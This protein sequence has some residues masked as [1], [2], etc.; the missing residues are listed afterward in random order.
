MRLDGTEEEKEK[1][2]KMFKYLSAF[3]DTFSRPV[4]RI[5]FLGLFDTVNS[6][7]RF[8]NA[9]MQR[10]KFPYTAKSSAI[11]IRHAV[12]IDER[13]AKFRQDLIGH[14][15][16]HDK[17]VTRGRPL[18]NAM[19]DVAGHLHVPQKQPQIVQPHDDSVPVNQRYR[20]K[21]RAHRGR[22]LMG[23]QRDA[24][25]APSISVISEAPETEGTEGHSLRTASSNPSL[26]PVRRHTGDLEEDEDDADEAIPQDLEEIWFP[27]CHAV[28]SAH[29]SLIS[30]HR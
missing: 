28:R 20:R 24:S 22:S 4:R 2:R 6:V 21:S 23:R 3:R 1:K 14:G 26:R 27:G 29:C 19:A 18:D 11:M 9:W 8:E 5:R 16:S 13:R 17:L 30:G 25:P 12:G 7:P 15:K 10:S